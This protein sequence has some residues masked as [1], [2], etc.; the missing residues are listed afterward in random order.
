LI[1]PRLCITFIP[2]TNE[3]TKNMDVLSAMSVFR[4]VAETGN[5]SEVARELKLSQPTV[6]KHIAALE[7]HLNAKLLNRSTRQMSLTEVGKQYYGECVHILEQLV[8]TEATIRNQHSLPTGALR[9]N[10]PITFGELN[11]TPHIWEFLAQYPDLKIDLIMDDHYV[12]LVKEGLDLAIRVGPM[13]D[14]SLVARKIGNSPRVTVASPYYLENNGEPENLQDLKGH[15]CIV[16]TLLKT[17][18]D[19]H[20]TG[21]NGKENIRVDGHF[22]VNNPRIIRQAVLAGEGIAVT[23]IWLMGE[24][25]KSG[26]VKVILNDYIPTPLEIHAVYPERRFVPAKVRCFI[27][28]I[29]TKIN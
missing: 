6:S 5:F 16:Y 22:S 27:D 2:Y 29:K 20:F 3:W 13:N 19:W 15:K 12:D 1:I 24:F 14:S 21:P 4:R 28:Y 17:R 10:T 25:I 11:I 8:E 23:P 7:K 26:E 9:I 18:N